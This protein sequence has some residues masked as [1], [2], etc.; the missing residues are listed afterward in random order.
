MTNKLITLAL[1]GL[2]PFSWAA[3]L[4]KVEHP[5][6]TEEYSVISTVQRLLE[7]D[8]VIAMVVL[9]FAVV[10]PYLKLLV[11]AYV[12]L[13][14]RPGRFGLFPVIHFLS[15]W[16]MLDVFLVAVI[17]AAYQGVFSDFTPEWGLYL[18]VSLVVLSLGFGIKL[19]RDLRR[20]AG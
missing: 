17:V 13:S 10:A 7:E 11:A 14:E 3:P 12:Q 15:R 20:R 5:L 2:F 6:T 9:V 19:E 16:A 18:F 1:L 4:A 8:V